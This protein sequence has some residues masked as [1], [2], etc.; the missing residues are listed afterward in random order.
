MIWFLK[1]QCDVVDWIELDMDTTQQYAFLKL[2][3]N[4]T[5]D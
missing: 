3:L 5:C 2:P 1:T 4:I